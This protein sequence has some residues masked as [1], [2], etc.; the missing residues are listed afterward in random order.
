[1]PGENK[2]LRDFSEYSE[3]P[4]Y[5]C[6]GSECPADCD[7]PDG[8]EHPGEDGCTGNIKKPDGCAR[9]GERFRLRTVSE[10]VSVAGAG[11]VRRSGGFF[12]FDG[13]EGD[14]EDGF[15]FDEKIK[16]AREKDVIEMTAEA[17]V[18]LTGDG[19]LE[20]RYDDAVDPDGP[21]VRTC[22]SFDTAEPGLVT[23]ERRGAL[24][25]VMFFEEG[26]YRRCEYVTPF[27]TFEMCIYSRRVDNRLSESGGSLYLD[28]AA[29]MKGAAA[30]R[31]KLN[32]ELTKI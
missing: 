7:C 29:E 17:F 14:G 9:H 31:V 30:Q 2:N 10:T 32:L 27:M 20:I 24:R 12:D 8:C 16:T 3:Y 23:L 19:R 4:P 26:R 22:L 13:D 15:S 6:G 5:S 11:I 28:Y 25:T 1:M 21:A 18:E